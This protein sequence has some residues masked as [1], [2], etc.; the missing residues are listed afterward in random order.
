M[1]ELLQNAKLVPPV[2]DETDG[3]NPYHQELTFSRQKSQI[4]SLELS[5]GIEP[6]FVGTVTPGQWTEQNVVEVDRDFATFEAKFPK[7]RYK[8]PAQSKPKL[9]TRRRA[10][11]KALFARTQKLW[12]SNRSRCA[13]SVL[14]GQWQEDGGSKCPPETLHQ[15]WK[16]IFEKPS[17]ADDRTVTLKRN[18]QWPL[19][20]PSVL[21]EVRRNLI[22]IDS[23]TAAGPDGRK[24]T[25]IKAIPLEELTLL[26]NKWAFSGTLP[27]VLW[28]GRTSLIPKV[29]GTTEAAQHWPIGVSSLLVRIY[30]RILARRLDQFCPP[31]RRQ[32]GFRPG[33]GIAENTMLLKEILRAATDSAKPSQLSLV[34]LDV[35]KAFDS[36]SHES[37]QL[38]LRRAG[39]PPPLLNYF[40]GIYSTSWTRILSGSGHGDVVKPAQGV[41]QGDPLSSFIFNAVIDWTMERLNTKIG[42]KIKGEVVSYFAFADDLVVLARSKVGLSQQAT[43]IVESLHKSGLEVNPS[44]CASLSLVVDGK[45]GRWAVDAESF[46][47]INSVPVPAL[48]V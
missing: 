39:L 31:S 30:H 8:P 35:K 46:L 23:Q 17:K 9:P 14:S 15:F 32:K 4:R 25:D 20:E 48:G 45:T 47:Q 42:Y 41:R 16:E 10:H 33:D 18:L 27:S 11:R 6:C 44:K 7:A 12:S 22:S 28:E 38:A 21:D 19:L 36:V 2:S 3:I 29:A 5:L 43:N 1:T 24:M 34:F 13:K 37:I 40:A 26:F